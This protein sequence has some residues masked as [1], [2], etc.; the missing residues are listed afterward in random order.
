MLIVSR[1]EFLMRFTHIEYVLENGQVEV[2]EFSQGGQC[3][4]VWVN[5]A[6]PLPPT[7]VSNWEAE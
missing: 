5:G 7:L 6:V 1:I 4:L 2:F 3:G